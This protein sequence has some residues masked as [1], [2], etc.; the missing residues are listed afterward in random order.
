VDPDTS[1]APWW[2]VREAANH[3]RCSTRTIYGEVRRGKLR[4]AKIGGRRQLRFRP[5][6][7]DEWIEN[8]ITPI[9]VQW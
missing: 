5:S 6:W 7:V 1:K 9:E 3:A 2:T 4:A 8:S